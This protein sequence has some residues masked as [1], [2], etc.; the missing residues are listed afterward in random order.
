MDKSRRA[1]VNEMLNFTLEIL[2]LLTG[3]DY[4]TFKLSDGWVAPNLKKMQDPTMELP[5]SSPTPERS[6]TKKI[7]EVTQKFIELLTGEVPIRYQDVS[8]AVENPQSSDGHKEVYKEVVVENYP[9]LDFHGKMK[10]LIYSPGPL[11][12]LPATTASSHGQVNEAGFIIAVNRQEV[13]ATV[14]ADAKDSLNHIVSI[15]DGNAVGNIYNDHG[16]TAVYTKE[17]LVSMENGNLTTIYTPHEDIAYISSEVT[18]ISVIGNE[19]LP[20]NTI[21]TPQFKNQDPFQGEE[22]AN[23]IDEVPLPAKKETTNLCK[24]KLADKRKISVRSKSEEDLSRKL[25]LRKAEGQKNF[26]CSQCNK[27]FSC[28]SLLNRHERIHTGLKPF[29]CP[30]CGRCFNRVENLAAHVRIH[31]GEK[32][33]SCPCGRVFLRKESL[34]LHKRTHSGEKP[35]SCTDCLKSFTNSSDLARH[36]RIHLNWKPFLCS[37]CGKCFTNKADLGRHQKTHQDKILPCP[38]CKQRFAARSDLLRH[39]GR[40]QISSLKFPCPECGKQFPSKSELARHEV[41]H[42]GEKPFECSECGKRFNR[43]YNLDSHRRTHL[44]EKPFPC[45][46]C[47]KRFLRKSQLTLHVRTHTGERPYSC[48]ECGKQFAGSSDLIKH[49]RLHTGEKPY[50]CNN[51]GRR[52]TNKPDLTKHQRVHGKETP[53]AR[54]QKTQAGERPFCCTV[55]EQLFLSNVD[56]AGHQRAHSKEVAFSC[57]DCGKGFQHEIDLS[58]H[59]ST[60]LINESYPFLKGHQDTG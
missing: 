9:T 38:E 37:E 10:D 52:F 11:R 20:A 56:L 33:F 21:Y 47:G 36:R 44:G 24:A 25:E 8:V 32:T 50:A 40:H 22:S 51:C 26:S 6:N 45:A 27:R 48:S 1:L 49:Q 42:S 16:Y 39:L 23:L 28:L 59:L 15:Q 17:V 58:N 29:A 13:S 60:H 4:I 53:F 12:G 18:E 31:K 19:E 35:F 43:A 46:E 5:P 41:T 2:Y 34:V 54:H 30:E 3:E 7:L 14:E 55:C 57:S